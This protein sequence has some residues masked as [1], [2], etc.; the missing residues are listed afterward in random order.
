MVYSRIEGRVRVTPGKGRVRR[1]ELIISGRRI[2]CAGII[3]VM[4]RVG[5]GRVTISRV[6]WWRVCIRR[7]M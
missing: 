7:L 4:W 1:Q 6:I 5:V 3:V 2:M